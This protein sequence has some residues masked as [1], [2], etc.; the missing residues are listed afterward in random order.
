MDAWQSIEYKKVRTKIQEVIDILEKLEE[1]PKRVDQVVITFSA[2]KQW[3]SIP[4]E[5]RSPVNL[6]FF[7]LSVHLVPRIRME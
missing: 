1:K 2:N 3:L 4:V 6:T 5:I 7:H